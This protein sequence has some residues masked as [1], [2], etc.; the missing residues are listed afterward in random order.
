MR[1]GVSAPWGLVLRC[2]KTICFAKTGLVGGGGVLGVRQLVCDPIVVV[3]L[4]FPA[5]N[6][7]RGK[8]MVSVGS[9]A[10]NE[11][12]YRKKNIFLFVLQKN[13]CQKRSSG[14]VVFNYC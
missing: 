11:N 10:C 4:Q 1:T 12:K 9:K 8:T 13:Y 3:Q 6:Q 2:A 5:A 14:H 7:Q